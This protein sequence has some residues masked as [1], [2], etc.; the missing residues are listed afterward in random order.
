[1]ASGSRKMLV[2]AGLLI[3]AIAAV[4]WWRRG[5]EEDPGT[6]DAPERVERARPPA[7]PPAAGPGQRSDGAASAPVER[8]PT[9]RPP[10]AKIADVVPEEVDPT[11]N[12]P[13]A[14]ESEQMYAHVLARIEQEIAEAR[15]RGD[16]DAVDRLQIRKQ[17]L[18]RRRA[19]NLAGKPAP[20]P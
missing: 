16:Q 17:R 12:V 3:I 20:T 8:D 10:G 1:M 19:A 7:E 14:V 4:W 11:E 9:G 13:S 2:A 18:E 6:D 5:R 15:A